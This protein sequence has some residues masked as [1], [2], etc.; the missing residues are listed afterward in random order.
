M[1]RA[2]DACPMENRYLVNGVNLHCFDWPASADMIE[3]APVLLI[4][5]T[6]FHARCWDQIIRHLDGRRVIA[7]DQ[8]GHGRSGKIPPYTWDTFG[9]DLCELITLLGLRDVIAVGHSMGGHVLVQAAARYPGVFQRLL[10]I[11]PVIFPPERYQ[12]PPMW[13]RVED[14]PTTRRRNTWPSWQVMAEHFRDR[15]PFATWDPTVLE[16]YCRHGLLPAADEDGFVLACPPE[17]E[18]SVYVNHAGCNVH[19]LIAE[20]QAPVTVLRARLPASDGSGNHFSTSPTWPELA[21]HFRQ[22]R[23][24]HLEQYNH[25]IPMEAPERVADHILDRR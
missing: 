19:G 16:D 5:A 20:I 13:D 25:L 21:A 1:T 18:A 2:S 6:G 12:Q 8:R 9:K 3:A 22:G 14:H 11:D 23:D 15:P 10:L 4:H 24:V 17:V 7:F